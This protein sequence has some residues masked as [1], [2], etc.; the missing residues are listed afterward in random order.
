MTQ[1]QVSYVCECE[2]GQCTVTIKRNE[3]VIGPPVI[4][5]TGKN[6]AH[7]LDNGTPRWKLKT[8]RFRND[9]EGA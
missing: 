5:V 9:R 3:G 4:C 1:Y 7:V 8:E 2:K 6:V